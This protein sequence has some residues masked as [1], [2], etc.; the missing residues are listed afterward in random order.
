MGD[1]LGERVLQPGY[2]F[3]QV[4]F[5]DFQGGHGDPAGVVRPVK[6]R[7]KTTI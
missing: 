1:P 7:K 5:G 3:G 2:G 6:R 4:M